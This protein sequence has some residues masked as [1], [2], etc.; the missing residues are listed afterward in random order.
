MGMNAVRNSG[1]CCIFV[2]HMFLFAGFR[3]TLNAT[4]S[5]HCSLK[6]CIQSL[7][8]H[9]HVC[10]AY[11]H[12]GIGQQAQHTCGKSP[13]ELL[14]LLSGV[15]LRTQACTG[16]IE[17]CTWGFSFLGRPGLYQPC[18][19]LAASLLEGGQSNCQALFAMRRSTHTYVPHRHATRMPLNER[20]YRSNHEQ[21]LPLV[22]D[23]VAMTS[24]GLLLRGVYCCKA[25]RCN[26]C[27]TC[28]CHPR[29]V[30]Q[31]LLRHLRRLL[32]QFEGLA[33]APERANLTAGDVLVAVPRTWT[34]LGTMQPSRL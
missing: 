16:G 34:S 19:A 11:G 23:P 21:N 20:C 4:S 10:R 9:W 7:Q 25:G 30:P 18:T 13:S 32:Q 27:S 15:C 29:L 24:L 17:A 14:C 28:L 12:M 8:G 22:P 31:P 26:N 5:L 3:Q 2:Y 33:A 1:S 6:S